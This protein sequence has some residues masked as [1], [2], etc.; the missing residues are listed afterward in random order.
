[1][2]IYV[3]RYCGVEVVRPTNNSPASDT[4]RTGCMAKGQGHV[5]IKK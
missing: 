1:M 5:Y 4:P 3:C 2:T